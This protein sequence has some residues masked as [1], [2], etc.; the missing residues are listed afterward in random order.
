MNPEIIIM[1]W[2]YDA[3][4]I[5]EGEPIFQN[6]YENNFIPVIIFSAVAETIRLPE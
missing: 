3:E 2:M 4:A 1:D 6:V 5:H